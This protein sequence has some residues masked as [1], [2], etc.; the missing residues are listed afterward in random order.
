MEGLATKAEIAQ[1]QGKDFAT[2]EDVANAKVSMI[3]MWVTLAVIVGMAVVNA[4]IRF[5]L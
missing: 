3:T 1:I 4:L 5:L 2:K